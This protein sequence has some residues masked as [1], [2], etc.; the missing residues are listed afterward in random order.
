MEAA[1][2]PGVHGP[3]HRQ[4]G[5]GQGGEVQAGGLHGQDL[6]RPEGGGQDRP[7][8]PGQGFCE[9]HVH[10]L[11][12]HF[13]E[14]RDEA[15]QAPGL[16]LRGDPGCRHRDIRHQVQPRQHHGP[17]RRRAGALWAVLL[18]PACQGQVQRVHW[19]LLLQGLGRAE[20]RGNLRRW[21]QE[22]RPVH[23]RPRLRRRQGH[24]AQGQ[25]AARPVRQLLGEARDLQG[26]LAPG[27]REARDPEEGLHLRPAALH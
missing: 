19:A 15:R 25:G 3:R 20:V 13:R 24:E 12:G 8:G 11:E 26:L 23:L 7:C 21:R 14:V 2:T 5:D 4:A 16:H 6:P 18:L 22:E 10:G 27:R 17:R 1:G 9:L